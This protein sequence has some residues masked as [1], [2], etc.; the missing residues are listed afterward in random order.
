MW[1]IDIYRTHHLYTRRRYDEVVLRHSQKCCSSLSLWKACEQQFVNAHGLVRGASTMAISI[2]LR[3]SKPW[4]HSYSFQPTQI[5]CLLLVL[6]G[7][8][9][10][11]FIRATLGMVQA[12]KQI[13]QHTWAKRC[14][15]GDLQS[16]FHANKMHGGI[17]LSSSFNR[18]DVCTSTFNLVYVR[19]LLTT[20][21]SWALQHNSGSD[22]VTRK[23][24]RD[25]K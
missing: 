12:S 6:L 4:V 20:T 21:D 10:K 2:N 15:Q 14:S 8:K 17:L 16:V 25:C 19:C 24:T 9:H 11:G 5:R 13:N 22:G 18:Y 23:V 7:I 3:T 1:H